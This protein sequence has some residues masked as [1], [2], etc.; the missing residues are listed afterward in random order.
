MTSQIT[1]WVAHAGVY[2]V[3]VLMAVD[4]L[5]PV[6]GELIML[7]AGVIAAGAIAGESARLF[8]VSLHTGLESFLVLA[9]AGALGYLAGSIVGWLIGARGGRA[10]VERHGRWL[11]VGPDTLA[12]AERW[13]ERRGRAAVFLGRITPLVRS[14]ISIPAGVLG[15]PFPSYVLLTLL[16]SL[17]WCFA[18]AGVGWALGGSWQ[19]FHDSFRYAD[20]AA[21]VGVLAIVAAFLVHRRGATA[22]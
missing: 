12:R 4:A 20:Y 14:F 1:H 22:A 9:I 18:F 2:A 3:F 7:Y 10:L 19:G 11:H 15:S 6:G 13:F 17:I 16:G 21:V 8:G 5:L